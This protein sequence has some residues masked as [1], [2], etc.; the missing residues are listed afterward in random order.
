VRDGSVELHFV[1][2]GRAFDPV[3][4]P[5]PADVPLEQ[6]AVGGVG[7]PLLHRLV[8]SMQYERAGA[9]NHLHLV[10]RDPATG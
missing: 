3:A 7:I 9:A 6:R 2:H 10:I 4:A 1:D 5:E 8:T